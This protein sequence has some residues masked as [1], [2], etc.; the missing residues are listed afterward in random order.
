MYQNRPYGVGV[1]TLVLTKLSMNRR[2]M[3]VFW[4][5]VL[6]VRRTKESHLRILCFLFQIIKALLSILAGKGMSRGGL[7][8]QNG[9]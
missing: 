7:K 8:S 4:I 2:G 1:K 6:A 5:F 9:K 3:I